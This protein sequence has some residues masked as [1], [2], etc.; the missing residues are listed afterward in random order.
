MTAKL[1]LDNLVA[2]SLQIG[3]LVALAAFVPAILR[4]RLPGAKLAYWHVLLAACL[5]LP[6]LG[7]R[8]REVTASNVQISTTVAVLAAAQPAPRLAIP[9]TELALVLLAAGAVLRLG[10]LAA[11][12]WRLR[13]YRRHSRPL[14]LATS[15]G[16]EADLRISDAIASPVT[17][18]FRQPVVLLPA[19]FPE[20]DASLREAI[21]CHEVLHVRR[22]DW[23]FTLAEE[24]VRAVFW[25][26]PAIWWLL[27][28]I[29]LARE[30]AVDRQV[31]ALTHRR[32]EY[33]DALLAIAG[34]RPQL[35]LAP[36]PLFLRKRHL[37]QRVV[38]IL[39]EV[40]MSKARLI[41]ALTAGLGILAV[42]CW[43]VTSTFPLTAAPQAPD[44]A[45]VTVEM[46]G[47]NVMHR[48]PVI[49]PD[50]A[51]RAGVEGTVTLELTTDSNGNVSDARVLSGPVPLRRSAIQSVLQWHLMKSSSP[52]VRT[53]S[54]TY[55]L[56]VR[57]EI[58]ASPAP[59]PAIRIQPAPNAATPAVA[60]MPRPDPLTGRKLAHINIVGLPDQ[61]R[62]DLLSQLPLHE[63]DTLSRESL[64]RAFQVVREFDEHLNTA[65]VTDTNGEPSLR[66]AAPGGGVISGVIGGVPGGV[67]FGVG[68]GV[69]GGVIG[70]VPGGVA[71]GVA[72]ADPRRIT[73]GGNMQQA[74]LI[75]QPRPA[76]PPE[77]KMERIQGVVSLQAVIAADGTM[78]DLTVISGHPLLVPAAL[79]AVKQWVYST[80]LLNGEPVE[81]KTQID[82]NFTLSQ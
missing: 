24:V 9:R 11:G 19:R 30:Q 74:K 43:F 8:A 21:L 40:R 67:G 81:I 50:A 26:H 27:G 7:P 13:Q 23:L 63:G 37:K 77:A 25:F 14:E 22:R 28:E 61:A 15:W 20:L 53:V 17:F 56:P 44:G 16:V 1:I 33:L 59:Q 46:G 66:I 39:K 12:F 65:I 38:S 78:K 80:T 41:S 79:D 42:A 10:W 48:S 2:Y 34:A 49:Y 18:G 75:Y 36:A 47:A 4:L 35:D 58:Q 51:R 82:V 76:Y 32:E 73:I 57:N 6:V 68:V 3:L 60:P 71:S 29:G 52:D 70:G 72:S 62:A 55:Q 5:L 45:G 54:I 31:I 64:A 69:G